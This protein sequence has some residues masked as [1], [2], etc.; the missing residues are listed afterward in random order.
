[1]ALRFLDAVAAR[2]RHKC[3]T[4]WAWRTK[5]DGEFA[6]LSWRSLLF[7][8]ALSSGRAIAWVVSQRALTSQ[9]PPR[10]RNNAS[11]SPHTEISA[12]IS[13]TAYPAVIT[14]PIPESTI[15]TTFTCQ[16]KGGG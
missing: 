7:V 9:E 11:V 8:F 10:D 13:P 5:A 12:P 14:H 2:D 3:H 16:Q 6:L 1:L 15:E 4:S